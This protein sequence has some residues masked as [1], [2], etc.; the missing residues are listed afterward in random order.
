MK[1]R[2]MVRSSLD[3]LLMLEGFD[4]TTFELKKRPGGKP[5]GILEGREV[6]IG[7]SHCKSLLV[8]ALYIGGDA[9]IDVEQCERPLHPSLRK[10]I[11]HP[12]DHS[13]ISEDLCGIRL[14][15]VK[16]AVL[17][18][19]GT[20]LRLAMNKIKLEELDQYRFSAEL[21]SQKLTVSSFP[22]R[23]HWVALAYRE[24]D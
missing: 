24:Q 21:E 17:K 7:I 5:Y 6:G 20:G 3:R 10:R 1:T 9:G 8:C 22:F 14:W 2:E 23:N 15:T 19:L 16:E 13:M 12:D 11:V 18:Y 4:P